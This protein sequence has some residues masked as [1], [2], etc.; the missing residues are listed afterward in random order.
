[1]SF[2]NSVKKSLRK[3]GIGK[4]RSRSPSRL[5]GDRI[6]ERL[7]ASANR[8]YDER[9][10]LRRDHDML[11]DAYDDATGLVTQDLYGKSE[12]KKVR[13]EIHKLDQMIGETARSMEHLAR[14][15]KKKAP[16]K[17]G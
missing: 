3:L 16:L 13:D 10:A 12:V 17:F 7:F 2:G 1:M 8:I 15:I 5:T 11:A 9:V 4:K 14:L 6:V